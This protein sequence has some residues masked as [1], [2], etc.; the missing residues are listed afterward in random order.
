MT[1]LLPDDCE[2]AL[3]DAADR[4]GNFHNRVRFLPVVSSTNELALSLAADGA[5][6]GT[7]IMAE[8]QTSGRGRQGRSWF[9]PKGVG[10]YFSSVLR[11]LKPELVTLMAG[12]AICEAVRNA[13]GLR[14]QLKWPNDVVL[15]TR[16]TQEEGS[17]LVKIAGILTE[18]SRS[19]E[20]V[21]AIIVGIGINISRFKYPGSLSSIASSLESELGEPVDRSTVLVESLAALSR[22]RNVL[23]EGH[24]D[25]LLERWRALSPS[26]EGAV[27]RWKENE[28][29]LVGVTDGI[30]NDGA[31]RVR[32]EGRVERVVAGALE[33]LNVPV[34][35][36]MDA[37]S[38]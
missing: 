9:S 3:R 12:V 4:L 16:S 31:L 32:C 17:N 33:W 20:S 38:D 23:V 8:S 18:T 29:Q 7:T 28:N 1:E 24:V 34:D 19:G 27:V 36:E 35:E 21:G 37:S 14:V 15:V 22:W 13:V 2:R 26:S 11:G 6:D 10:L 30:D 25:R 5:D